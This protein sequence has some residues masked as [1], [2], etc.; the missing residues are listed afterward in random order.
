MVCSRHLLLYLSAHFHANAPA[1]LL[2]IQSSLIFLPFNLPA[3][4]LSQDSSSLPEHRMAR[5]KSAD[6]T[7]LC[8]DI[9]AGRVMEAW[10]FGRA[11]SGFPY[12]AVEGSGW[13]DEG[14]LAKRGQEC[15]R[16]ESKELTLT[17][18]I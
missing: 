14:G 3:R 2:A 11:T 4:P 13:V 5:G 17:S 15:Y 10:A 12:K 18:D 7:S 8:P 9:I 1:T 16:T 6:I